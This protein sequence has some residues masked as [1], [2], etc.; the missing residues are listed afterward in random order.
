MAKISGY[1]L[2]DKNKNLYCPGDGN[3]YKINELKDNGWTRGGVI[4]RRNSMDYSL[5]KIFVLI[6]EDGSK[7][8]IQKDDEI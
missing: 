3:F 5:E 6:M 2:F 7:R 4:L 1:F 8:M